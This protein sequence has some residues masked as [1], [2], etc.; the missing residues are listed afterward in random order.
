MM[1][2]N[3]GTVGTKITI[4]NARNTRPKGIGVNNPITPN[5]RKINPKAIKIYLTEAS[6]FSSHT[7]LYQTDIAKSNIFF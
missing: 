2:A 5:I 6:L 1:R 4:D 3:P 7:A